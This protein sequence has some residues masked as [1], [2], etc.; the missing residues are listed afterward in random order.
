MFDLLLPI[1]LFGTLCMFLDN[2]RITFITAK[3]LRPIW[4][5]YGHYVEEALD[6]DTTHAKKLLEKINSETLSTSSWISRTLPFL[7]VSLLLWPLNLLSLLFGQ[8]IYETKIKELIAKTLFL[9]IVL[10]L[11]SQRLPEEQELKTIAALAFLFQIEANVEV[12]PLEAWFIQDEKNDD[13]V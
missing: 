13:H 12:V 11:K 9:D 1:W 2:T 7:R 3:S 8:Q 6:G 5:N 4:Q 10:V